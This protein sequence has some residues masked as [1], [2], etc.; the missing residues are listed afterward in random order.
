MSSSEVIANDPG[1]AYA[2]YVPDASVAAYRT[3]WPKV[4]SVIHP[5][6]ELED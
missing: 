6:S 3:A 1:T 5:M 4:A 2:V